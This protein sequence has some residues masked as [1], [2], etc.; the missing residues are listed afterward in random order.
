MRVYALL[1]C[2]GFANEA[3]LTL[4]YTRAARGQRWLCVLLSLAQQA[5]STV[6]ICYTLV[7]VE[8]LSREQFIRWG[9]SALSYG[10]ATAWVVRPQTG[11]SDNSS[12]KP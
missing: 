3:L 8:P 10:C 12:A 2:L 1:F 7:D 4:Y 11:T 5:V 6:A 9:V